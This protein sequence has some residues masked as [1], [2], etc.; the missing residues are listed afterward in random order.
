[1]NLTMAGFHG[2]ISRNRCCVR[3]RRHTNETVK[4]EDEMVRI[5]M[6]K[7]SLGLLLLVVVVALAG[8]PG[9]DPGD[10][11]EDVADVVGA[12]EDLEPE[13]LDVYLPPTPKLVVTVREPDDSPCKCPAD[14]WCNV[15][16]QDFNI[17][18]G[19]DLLNKPD[20]KSVGVT[21]VSL[22]HKGADGEINVIQTADKPETHPEDQEDY[23]R[24]VFNIE[25]IDTESEFKDGVHEL[26]VRVETDVTYDLDGVM[27]PLVSNQK[28]TV[29]VDT[30]PP[31]MKI[32]F[33]TP[34]AGGV[35]AQYLP[36]AYC[37]K[38]KNPGNSKE[39]GS[40]V[41][42][43]T[44]RFFLDDGEEITELAYGNSLN[45]M[46]P[47]G[48]PLQ[49]NVA[50]NNTATYE[51][52]MVVQDCVGNTLV[53][54]VP[55]VTVVGLPDY[56]VPSKKPFGG[57]FSSLLGNVLWTRPM[58]IG[59][60]EGKQVYYPDE[61]P[62]LALF[63]EHGIAF[64]MNDGT[65]TIQAPQMVYNQ[66]DGTDGYAW[67]INGDGATD[68]V[69]L[70]PI[71]EHTYLRIFLQD[72]KWDEGELS[73]VPNGTFPDDP[74]ESIFL[75]TNT[76]ERMDR[77]DVNGDGFEDLLVYGLEDEDTGALLLHTTEAIPYYQK[78]EYPSE[79]RPKDDEGKFLYVTEA[80]PQ[81]LHFTIHDTL[82]GIGG[83]SDA[84]IG[85]FRNSSKSVLGP[86]EIV[87]VRPEYGLLTVIP[88][89]NDFKFGSAVDTLYCWGSA[90]MIAKP[91][92]LRRLAGVADKGTSDIW[93]HPNAPETED[94]VVYSSTTTALHFVPNKGNGQFDLVGDHYYCNTG[95]CPPNSN[96]PLCFHNGKGIFGGEEGFG[97]EHV[98][99]S[100]GFLFGQQSDQ[101][102]YGYVTY[103]G[104]RP[105]GIWLGDIAPSPLIPQ[106]G[107][108]DGILDVIVPVTERNYI[109]FHPGVADEGAGAGQFGYGKRGNPGPKPHG[110]TVADFDLDGVLDVICI[111]KTQA[112]P[113]DAPCETCESSERESFSQF[114]STSQFLST[115]LPLPL[116][117]DWESG[118]V[119]PSHFLVADVEED[120]DNDVIVAT[121]PESMYLQAGM[122]WNETWNPDGMDSA[123]VPV[124]VAYRLESGVPE[125]LMPDVSPVDL[126]FNQE[127]SS[128]D[129]GDFN[130]DGHPDLVVSIDAST[131][132]A[133]EGRTV[134]ILLGNRGIDGTLNSTELGADENFLSLY[135]QEIQAKGQFLPL[136]GFFLLQSVTGVM[137]AH[138]NSDNIDDLIVFGKE[139]GS[140]EYYQ[141]HQ[142]AT[143]LT[144]FDSDWNTCA[145]EPMPY[146]D[147]APVHPP[148]GIALP[149]CGA[150]LPPIPEP[151]DEDGIEYGCWPGYHLNN[152]N[153]LYSEAEDS[154][155][156]GYAA[157]GLLPGQARPSMETVQFEAGETPVAGTTGDFYSADG[158]G[159]DGCIDFF[160][161][162]AGTHNATFVRG[163]CIQ[164]NYEFETPVYLF[165]IGE[166]PL[167]I[168][169][170][171]LNHD[172]FID[173]V[174]ALSDNI[175]LMYGVSGEL[176]D[177]PQYLNQGE[178]F[179]DLAPTEIEVEDVNDDGWVD[180]LVISSN[181][182]SILVYLNGGVS[183]EEMVNDTPH[184]TRFLGPYVI[185]VGVDPTGILVAP[186]FTDIQVDESEN[187]NDLAVLNSGSGT[188]TLLRNR[189]CKK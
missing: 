126:D 134:D 67:D 76:F 3:V 5:C 148:Q 12:I 165:P 189:R 37:L 88:L 33:T 58:H 168:K 161:A 42:T 167:E 111:V 46:C 112:G 175:S 159:A 109:A 142:I 173:T 95:N 82:Q 51:F 66:V 128:I 85:Q 185:P 64:A 155:Y 124:I 23:Y 68:L 87:V 137:T 179:Q 14:G 15:T 98:A 152:E 154:E 62:D 145:D 38:D 133:C 120:G 147:W 106:Q 72:V 22:L 171:D 188:V 131:A 187:C 107:V 43:E 60:K 169:T 114:S 130:Q 96:V 2:T 178:L 129:T 156:T 105:D 108:K 44:A 25:K 83:I 50:Q 102:E 11:V 17:Y 78:G 136:G 47:V 166:D 65:G 127:L 69:V 10:P 170:A 119:T 77:F 118:P 177:S 174:A 16:R 39:E 48:K 176:F 164:D 27:S 183:A 143:Y 20:D 172:D 32:K 34:V 28:I 113:S 54:S 146:F 79:D 74:S 162:N 157:Q 90:S 140:D 26:T 103:V 57:T 56:D 104:E 61:Y 29:M 18:V 132:S 59:T 186:I 24:L 117:V 153:T 158:S 99:G 73:W 94:L 144:N 6:R 35:Y 53:E 110:C 49:F 8:C 149:V 135:D 84:Y 123:S 21:M 36:A 31:Q 100:L 116:S 91:A 181:H 80:L 75:T 9:T 71:N 63:L 122:A 115:E 184:R 182:D 97:Q 160:V 121:T 139:Y 93:P 138:L 52:Q 45:P 55:D 125:T 13:A 7:P 41:D 86:P 101:S 163:V 180:L 40:G 151:D 141:P 89:D 70:D 30:A 19:V 81:P 1:V 92:E 4:H 150:E